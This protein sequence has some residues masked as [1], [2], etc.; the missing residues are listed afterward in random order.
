VPAALRDI[1]IL[2][3]LIESILKSPLHYGPT[4]IFGLHDLLARTRNGFETAN[5]QDAHLA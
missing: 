4:L 2:G 3:W 5:L 1:D